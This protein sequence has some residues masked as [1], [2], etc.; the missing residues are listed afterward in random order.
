MESKLE[1]FKVK[2]NELIS[3]I[4]P[5]YNHENYIEECIDSIINQS[6]KNIELIILND[7]SKDK[8]AEKIKLKS[9]ECK[10]RFKRFVFIDKK[11]NDGVAK[12]LNKGCSIAEGKYL[13]ICASDDSFVFNAFEIMYDFLENNQEYV[14]AVGDNYFIDAMSKRCYWKSYGEVT[15][16]TE[17]SEFK[18]FGDFLKKNRYEINFNSEEF[19][20]YQSFLKGN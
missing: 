14:L 4:V 17:E 5:A 12:T 7:G 10:I 13:T 11:N 6:Y 1:H 16:K 19:G 18:T 20:T 15:Y 8:T 2:N 9:Q 3:V